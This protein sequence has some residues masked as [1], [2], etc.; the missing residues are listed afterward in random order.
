M[1]V[2]LRLP[3]LRPHGGNACGGV[4]RLRGTA[5]T[6]RS[7]AWRAWLSLAFVLALVSPPLSAQ[8]I[9]L[10]EA[11]IEYHDGAFELNANYDLELPTALEDALHKGI[12]LYFA[13]D[14]QLTRPRWY[15]F[16]DKPVSA[17]RSVRLTF[18]PLTRQYRVSTGG[19]QLPFMRLKGAIDFIK[20]VRGWRVFDRD[21]VKLG[22]P[23]QAEL[24]M[25]LDLSQLPKPFQVNAVNTRDWN[26][27]SDWRR[28][29][30]TP[31]PE[32]P[33]VRLPAG[34]AGRPRRRLPPR[35]PRPR[36]RLPCR[37]RASPGPR[38]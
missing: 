32:S 7:A 34:P 26:L 15:W 16:D 11:H 33:P 21:D 12:P 27:S 9:E 30:Y 37:R 13:V 20:Q 24:R 4:A 38:R 2:P 10:R 22:V 18:H 14:F 8:N 23:Y 29:T 17:S 3:V 5:R 28:F 36:H 19:L 25:R 1:P 35:R 6:L 31:V